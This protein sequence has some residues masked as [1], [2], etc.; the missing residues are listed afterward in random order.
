MREFDRGEFVPAAAGFRAISEHPF[1]RQI[2]NRG[3]ISA[4]ALRWAVSLS[5][6]GHSAEARQIAEKHRIKLRILEPKPKPETVSTLP[7]GNAIWSQTSPFPS[8]IEEILRSQYAEI[9]QRGFL[10]LSSFTPLV[11]GDLVISR[12]LAEVTACHRKTG[13]IVWRKSLESQTIQLAGQQGMLANPQFRRMLS[14]QLAAQAF[15]DRNAGTL[16]SDG[17]RVFAVLTNHTHDGFTDVSSS[18]FDDNLMENG[19]C[20]LLALDAATGKELWRQP[21]FL[22]HRD[23]ALPRLSGGIRDPQS[24]IFFFGPPLV[25]DHSLYIIGQKDREIRLYRLAA[26]TG[27]IAWSLLLAN[28]ELP[29]GKDPTPQ[30]V[31]VESR[32]PRRAVVVSHGSGSLS[33]GR[34][35]FPNLPLDFTLCP[36]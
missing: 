22:P 2:Q 12:G 10:P 16:S 15:A 26:E 19:N 25:L 1:S 36:R 24:N 14:R 27:E 4:D 23:P 33:G 11:V 6:L 7:S 20:Q 21:R 5:R 30:A 17:S 18:A 13:A 3:T 8:A 34:S 9:A 28:A 35:P 31:G 32:V 29:L